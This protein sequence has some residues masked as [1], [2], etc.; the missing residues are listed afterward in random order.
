MPYTYRA[1][2]DT[3]ERAALYKRMVAERLDSAAMCGGLDLGGWMRLTAPAI[4]GGNIL[5]GAVG[6][7]GKIHGVALF[8]RREYRMW[9]FDFTAFRGHFP[10]A[11]EMA[12]GG[13]SWLFAHTDATSIY[14]I[15]P[16]KHRHALGLAGACGFVEVAR[17]PLACWLARRGEYVDGVVL[18]ATPQ[19]LEIAMSFGGGGGGGSSYTPPVEPVKE[20]PKAEVT[21]P[22][23]EAATSARDAQRDKA[24]RAAGLQST[25]L[26]GSGAM[27]DAA[28]RGQKTL[29]GQ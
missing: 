10:A 16:V 2:T 9:R 25:I 8:S 23:T 12:R 26:T 17:L 20:T 29:L 27:L 28:N 21:K 24:S 5:L 13:F 4:D 1:I 15:A 11:V 7:D 18:L 3:A 14:G 6:D 22:V 19:T